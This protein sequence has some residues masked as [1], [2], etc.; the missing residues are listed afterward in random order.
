M[1]FFWYYNFSL[2]CTDLLIDLVFFFFFLQGKLLRSIS[3]SEIFP[4]R[5]K[6]RRYIINLYVFLVS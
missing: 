1:I 3:V 2:Y 6:S 5:E 4:F